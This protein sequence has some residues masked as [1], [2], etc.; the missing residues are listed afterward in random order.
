M[1]DQKYES[2]SSG[3]LEVTLTV[4]VA[5][6]TIKGRRDNAPRIATSRRD[7]FT[8]VQAPNG[9]QL[10]TRQSQ[11]GAGC[12]CG[13]GE[14]AD[15]ATGFTTLYF[16][17]F[18]AAPCPSRPSINPTSMRPHAGWVQ[19]PLGLSAMLARYA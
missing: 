6:P 3:P 4:K 17:V 13:E 1:P 9:F 7:N 2:P 19:G 14:P 8:R 15:C 10:I 12:A 5:P 11:K 16:E 18:A